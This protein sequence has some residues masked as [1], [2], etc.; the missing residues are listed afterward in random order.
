MAMSRRLLAF[1]LVT[2]CHE[3]AVAPPAPATT[4]PAAAVP[5][6]A[7]PRAEPANSQPK[8]P[9]SFQN[10]GN[11]PP[12]QFWDRWFPT[13]RGGVVY[14]FEAA[15]EGE[16]GVRRVVPELGLDGVLMTRCHSE[17]AVWV[18][19][20]ECRDADKLAHSLAGDASLPRTVCMP[21]AG[22]SPRTP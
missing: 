9:C 19:G 21:P 18:P 16:A 4:L 8:T 22:A 13:V 14:V 11:E 5:S 3:R 12:S 10:E 20:V 6:D 1:V 7:T 2:A 15:E 17:L